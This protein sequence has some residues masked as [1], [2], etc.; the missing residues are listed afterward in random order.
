MKK[1]TLL[2]WT[3]SLLAFLSLNGCG[4][5]IKGLMIYDTDPTLKTIKQVRALPMR[6]SVG[7]EWKK[8]EDYRVHG[9]NIYRGIP[10]T[11]NQSFK[12]IGSAGNRYATHF[13]DTHVKPDRTYLYTFTTFSLG[14]E[15]KH[16]TVL[17]VKTRPAL[18]GVSF[19]KAYNVAPGVVKLL[20]APHNNE[21]INKYII[22][23]SVNMGPWQY[24]TQVDGQL[25]AE[26]ID[27]FVHAGNNYRYRII[28]K[29]Y[30]N[31]AT[32]PS[33]VTTISL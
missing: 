27:T 6:T 10:S 7:F 14:K 3:L 20:W 19:V 1:S 4:E 16:G 11:G 13:V 30:D 5:G 25:M 23:R 26:Y 33:Q 32:K 15:S 9:V 8:I 2:Q 17:K 21:S 28:A 18:H 24:V 29:S 12:R 22:E 31:I